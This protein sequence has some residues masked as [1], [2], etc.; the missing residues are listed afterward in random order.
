MTEDSEN[1]CKVWMKVK[2][3][4]ASDVCLS[5]MVYIQLL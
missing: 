1:S 5:E 2:M 3:E 4:I